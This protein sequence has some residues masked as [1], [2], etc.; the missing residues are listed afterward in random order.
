MLPDVPTMSELGYKNLDSPL[1][2]VLAVP[3]NTPSVIQ[4]KLHDAFS[5]ALKDSAVKKR[6]TDLG[7]EVVNG[8]PEQA[9]AVM[10]EDIKRWEGLVELDKTNK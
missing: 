5:R 1:W 4:Q 6:L 2:Y 7:V 9:S 10:N 3:K 8:G